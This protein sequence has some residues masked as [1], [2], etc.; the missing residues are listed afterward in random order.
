MCGGYESAG[1]LCLI[2]RNIKK[3]EKL[4][5]F[6]GF[7]QLGVQFST[8]WYVK[9]GL[10]PMTAELTADNRHRKDAL[11]AVS[12]KCECC[13]FLSGGLGTPGTTLIASPHLAK[14]QVW[15]A[16]RAGLGLS[17]HATSLAALSDMRE[18]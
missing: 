11:R 10:R 5:I 13:I 2:C 17:A 18:E 6:H 12:S 15:E 14:T 8:G 7:W 4:I 3:N 16:T 1:L 9:S